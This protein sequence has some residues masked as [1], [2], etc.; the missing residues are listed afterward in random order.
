VFIVLPESAGS[1]NLVAHQAF[2]RTGRSRGDF[3]SVVSGLNVGDRV[4]SAGV[5][6]VRNKAVIR[7]NNDLSPAA[8]TTP[9]PPNS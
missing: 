5:F 9:V 8:S 6:K 2:V 7:V 1:T 3:I 4:V